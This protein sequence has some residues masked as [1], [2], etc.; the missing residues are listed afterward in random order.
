MW[1]SQEIEAL[2]I[3]LDLEYFWRL[4]VKQWIKHIQAF[5]ET[6]S[7]RA[8]EIDQLNHILGKYIS[9]AYHDPRKY[10]NTPFLSSQIEEPLR[11]MTTEEMEK[12]AKYNTIKK[13]GQIK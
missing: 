3:G 8:K 12:M 9:F 6:E 5:N 1:R 2:R 13:G 7:R 11:D 10:P 4:N